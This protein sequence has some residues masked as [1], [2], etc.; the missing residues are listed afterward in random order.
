MYVYERKKRK[1]KQNE[2][3]R[4]QAHYTDGME[5]GIHDHGIPKWHLMSKD[6]S[7]PVKE[8][9]NWNIYNNYRPLYSEN[10]EF[11]SCQ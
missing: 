2:K 10:N 8:E 3:E 1:M 11:K 4:S 9:E 7:K 5:E 6:F